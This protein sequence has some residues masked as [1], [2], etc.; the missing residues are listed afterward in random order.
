VGGGGDAFAVG[1]DQLGDGVLIE[2]DAADSIDASH[3]APGAHTELAKTMVWQSSRSA[4][5]TECE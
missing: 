2:A 4:A 3:P 5:C 1:N